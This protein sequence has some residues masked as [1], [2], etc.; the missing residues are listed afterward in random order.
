[1]GLTQ[2]IVAGNSARFLVKPPPLVFPTKELWR[3]LCFLARAFVLVPFLHAHAA[4]ESDE[5]E[6]AKRLSGLE[7]SVFQQVRSRFGIAPA[8]RFGAQAQ[9]GL[10]RSGAGRPFRRRSP[11]NEAGDPSAGR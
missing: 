1:M 8:L 3:Y 2:E 4:A 9:C 5:S 6:L 10:K 11:L 7:Y